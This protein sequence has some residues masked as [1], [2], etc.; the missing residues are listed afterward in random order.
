[1]KFE[2]EDDVVAAP[3]PELFENNIINT[4][5]NIGNV[6]REG[7]KV[8]EKAYHRGYTREEIENELGSMDFEPDKLAM[9]SYICRVIKQMYGHYLI[10][11]LIY[12]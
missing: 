11:P 6:R 2:A 9:S 4:F 12:G 1:M 5:K 3:A 10:L 8:F 7:N